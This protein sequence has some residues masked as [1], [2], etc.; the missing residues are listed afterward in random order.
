MNQRT[1]WNEK[2]VRIRHK[3]FSTRWV[4]LLSRVRRAPSK[5]GIN[6]LVLDKWTYWLEWDKYHQIQPL[7]FSGLWMDL[8]ARVRRAPPESG[9][10][11][12]ARWAD[13][14]TAT[15]KRVVRIRNQ[16]SCTRKM[17]LL[18]SKK[19]AIRIW[20]QSSGARWVDLHP[21]VRK[22]QSV[23]GINLLGFTEETY[24]LQQEERHQD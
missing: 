21:R 12:R 4:D 6:L 17:N 23:S 8:L 9:I 14:H 3:S 11:F 18:P 1:A 13:L 10:H 20:H 15:K 19:S 2:S 7:I 24:P 22:A 16:S 5:S